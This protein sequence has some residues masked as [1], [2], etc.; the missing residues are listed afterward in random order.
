[1]NLKFP[2]F[3]FDKWLKEYMIAFLYIEVENLSPEMK[4]SEEIMIDEK[5]EHF[6]SQNHNILDEYWCMSCDYKSMLMN[7]NEFMKIISV[8]KEEFNL[9]ELFNHFAAGKRLKGTDG[10]EL[11]RRQIKKLFKTLNISLLDE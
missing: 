10:I 1:M 6:Y 2:N 3:N 9:M 7:F 8:R 4:E 11:G 5:K